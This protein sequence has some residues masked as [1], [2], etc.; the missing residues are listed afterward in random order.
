MCLGIP[1]RITEVWQEE[2]GAPM[3][4]AEFAGT[5]RQICLAYLPGLAVG[6]YVISHMGY[7]LTRVSEA[8]AA[9][10][11]TMMRKYGALGDPAGNGQPGTAGPGVPEGAAGPSVA[12]GSAGPGVP[13]GSANPG[14]QP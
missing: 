12:D 11:L 10:T 4:H 3:A 13:E 6:D 2:G 9:A 7:A 1:G 14:S 8:D 5:T